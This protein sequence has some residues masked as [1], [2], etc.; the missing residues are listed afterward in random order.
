MT[1]SNSRNSCL[2]L[3]YLPPPGSCLGLQLAVPGVFLSR[4]IKLSSSLLLSPSSNFF[5]NNTKNSKRG[6]HQF[7]WSHAAAPLGLPQYS[8]EHQLGFL[9]KPGESFPK[10]TEYEKVKCLHC[11]N[12]PSLECKKKQLQNAKA[13]YGGNTEIQVERYHEKKHISSSECF[14]WQDSYLTTEIL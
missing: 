4:S 3:L 14:S 10:P 8:Q 11:Q 6:V 9:Q 2:P 13:T 5:K 7:P 12:N 1:Q